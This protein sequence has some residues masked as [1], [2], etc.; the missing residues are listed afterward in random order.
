MLVCCWYASKAD[1]VWSDL[2]PVCR[3]V[4]LLTNYCRLKYIKEYTWKDGWDIYHKDDL[5][6][7]GTWRSPDNSDA[8]L[9]LRRV[10]SDRIGCALPNR[11]LLNY[12]TLHCCIL[13]NCLRVTNLTS[14][15]ISTSDRESLTI[16][17][18]SEVF[19]FRSR[20]KVAMAAVSMNLVTVTLNYIS[21]SGDY[22]WHWLKWTF[23]QKMFPTSAIIM[24]PR[25]VAS[26]FVVRRKT[27]NW[28]DF[29]SLLLDEIAFF[30]SMIYSSAKASLFLN[31]VL[32]IESWSAAYQQSQH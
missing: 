19:W 22:A 25:N 8:V 10:V 26:P 20:H 17:A 27:D 1:R 12:R 5:P 6:R 29:F 9:V 32:Y 30:F 11:I 23:I 31:F 14:S 21:L 2:L 13:T 24:K 3:P 28:N 4:L 7:H 18:T 16:E 15:R